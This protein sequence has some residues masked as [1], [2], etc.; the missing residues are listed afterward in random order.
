MSDSPEQRP[1]GVPGNDAVTAT[2]GSADGRRLSGWCDLP[3]SRLAPSIARR[4][5]AA[6]LDSWHLTLPAADLATIAELTSELVTNAVQHAEPGPSGDQEIR[7]NVRVD[8]GMVWLAVCDRDPTLPVRRTPDF[9]AEC[10]R[11]LFLVDAQADQWGF[12]RYHGGKYVWFGLEYPGRA[13]RPATGRPELIVAVAP[14]PPASPD[15]SAPPSTEEDP[16]CL[17]SPFPMSSTAPDRI[18]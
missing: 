2:T 6:M 18:G 9:V 4:W 11:G 12:V 15:P 3:G 17:P 1:T 14:E 5:V 16:V 7:V 13:H 10:G 8:Y